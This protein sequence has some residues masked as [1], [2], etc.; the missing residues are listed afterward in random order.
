MFITKQ[1]VRETPPPLPSVP[2]SGVKVETTQILA[3][4]DAQT[5]VNPPDYIPP[6]PKT[7][8]RLFDV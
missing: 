6:I 1:H 2:I 5:W 7:L 3:A 8:A 4:K